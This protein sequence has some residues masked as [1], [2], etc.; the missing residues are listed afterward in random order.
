MLQQP[1]SIPK[2]KEDIRLTTC[3][4]LS[5]VNL[6]LQ[7]TRY[8]LRVLA[9]ESTLSASPKMLPILRT[10]RQVGQVR[11]G[12]S[13][14]FVWSSM[15]TTTWIRRRCLRKNGIRKG[16]KW[17]RQSRCRNNELNDWKPI[18]FKRY[19]ES[20]AQISSDYK[21][22]FC[23]SQSSMADADI[24]CLL[25]RYMKNKKNHNHKMYL[26]ERGNEST[27]AIRL[28][29]TFRKRST[30]QI[31]DRLLWHCIFIRRRLMGCKAKIL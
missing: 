17:K 27:S 24:H 3:L 10:W 12:H 23:I 30:Y 15:T 31:S 19:C 7:W 28:S 4:L 26:S 8:L 29:W 11:Q 25:K 20:I 5:D 14:V 21:F 13:T 1:V 18:N 9:T 6:T 2:R 16:R 22:R